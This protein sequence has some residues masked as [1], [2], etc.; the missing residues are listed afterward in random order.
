MNRTFVIVVLGVA[1]IAICQARRNARERQH[2]RD[3]WQRAT[4]D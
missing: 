4:A 1:A 2:T 3:L